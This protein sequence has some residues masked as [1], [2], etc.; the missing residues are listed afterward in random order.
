MTCPV[1]A[2][3]YRKCGMRL[4]PRKQGEEEKPEPIE[5]PTMYNEAVQPKKDRLLE[6]I[7]VWE[8]WG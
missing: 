7:E 6:R 1:L 4:L 3:F 2:V 8:D 5:I